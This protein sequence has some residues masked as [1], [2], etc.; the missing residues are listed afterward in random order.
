M[1]IRSWYLRTPLCFA[2]LAVLCCTTAL[3]EAHTY[4]SVIVFGDSL[5]DTG[6]V[7]Y[8]SEVKYNIPFPA[9]VLPFEDY[10]LGHFTDGGET[11]PSTNIRGVWVEQLAAALPGQPLVVNS[12]IGGSNYAY[13]F[14]TTAK[15]SSA[16]TFS[17]NNIVYSIQI[18]NIGQQITA[19][20]G[21]HPHIDDHTLF[22]IWGGAIDVLNAASPTS[23]YNAAAQETLNIQRLI[24]AG[25][26]QILVP[27]LPPLGL[28]PRLNGSLATSA[29]GTSA[30]L[31]F[32]T[33]LG[34]GVGLLKDFYWW[35]HV[36]FYQLDV[37]HLFLQLVASPGSYSLTD[38]RDPAEGLPVNP[39]TF[40]FWDDLHPT[41][42]GHNILAAAALNLLS[43]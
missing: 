5:S 1:R 29:A 17:A 38:V 22:V 8:L 19:Y 25:A 37:F 30:S 14:A 18:K 11:I 39:D 7:L 42:R 20:L 6:N 16:L 31:L 28:V 2:A 3:A 21:T 15:S 34:A 24:R 40:L 27:N 35:R 32:N 9:T 36:T 4:N 33:Y 13:G 43:Q 12:L 41:T 10:T 26:T 23:I